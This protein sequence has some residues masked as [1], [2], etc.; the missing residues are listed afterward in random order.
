MMKWKSSAQEEQKTKKESYIVN[1]KHKHGQN[2]NLFIGTPCR[3]IKII[4]IVIYASHM[5]FVF[6]KK[7]MRTIKCEYIYS[8]H[9]RYLF[10]YDDDEKKSNNNG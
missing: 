1:I 3:L 4:I 6:K 7:H 5:F 10:C 2:Q 8:L 9:F